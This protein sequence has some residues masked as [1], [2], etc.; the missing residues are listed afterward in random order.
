MKGPKER[1]DASGQNERDRFA[2]GTGLKVACHFFL[3]GGFQHG[4]H[5]IGAATPLA[6]GKTLG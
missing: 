4:K 6:E 2:R 1:R 5:R 3:H